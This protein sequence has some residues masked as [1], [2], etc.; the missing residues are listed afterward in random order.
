M[1]KEKIDKEYEFDP[2]TDSLLV[3]H[4]EMDFEILQER[5]RIRK[6]NRCFMISDL[7]VAVAFFTYQYCIL[8]TFN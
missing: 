1:Y 2:L 3:R 6:I 5:K 4:D 8:V 7:I